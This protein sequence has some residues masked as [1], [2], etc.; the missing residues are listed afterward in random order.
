MKRSVIVVLALTTCLFSTQALAM[1]EARPYF[2]LGGGLS[3]MKGAG[4]SDSNFLTTT[5]IS[6]KPGFNAMIATG[7]AW[8]VGR[9]EF[10][11]GVLYEKLDQVNVAAS[12]NDT[13]GEITMYNLMMSVF[14]DFNKDGMISP[15]FGGGIGGA[16]LDIT[17]P[18]LSGND[19][20]SF[21]YQ[22]GAGLTL[23][24]SD[25]FVIDLGY[26]MV[27]TNKLDFGGTTSDYFIFQ[28][29]NVG[30]RFLF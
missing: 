11:G 23:N 15:Y 1:D 19:A 20:F 10:S 7:L 4:V 8:D 14:Y 6:V 21:A 2:T 30:L 18:D 29:A 16:R 12:W 17:S 28:N 5:R 26:R 9:L 13:S 24:T 25:N 3:K 27:G 22:L